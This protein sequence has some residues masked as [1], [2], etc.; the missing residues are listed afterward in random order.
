MLT[1]HP[2]SFLCAS[3]NNVIATAC[4]WTLL[5]VTTCESLCSGIMLLHTGESDILNRLT[6]S[7]KASDGLL[8][9]RALYSRLDCCTNDAGGDHHIC[10]GHVCGSVRAAIVLFCFSFF[11]LFFFFPFRPWGVK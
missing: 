8:F 5:A 7:C 2:P 9:L 1:P 3:Q 11:F 10:G 6:F 4:D